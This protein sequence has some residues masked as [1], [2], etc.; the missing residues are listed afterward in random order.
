MGENFFLPRYCGLLYYQLSCNCNSSILR[1]YYNMDENIS[2]STGEDW[3]FEYWY[4]C[5]SFASLWQEE[6][7][8]A[9]SVVFTCASEYFF[10]AQLSGPDCLGTICSIQHQIFGNLCYDM[11]IS[12]PMCILH[13]LSLLRLNSVL[14]HRSNSYNHCCRVAYTLSW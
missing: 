10:A 6:R 13:Y 9:Y 11:C 2:T 5:S 3:H 14:C 7:R 8:D 1:L 4:V 12:W